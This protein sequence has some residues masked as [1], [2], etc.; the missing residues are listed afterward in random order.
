MEGAGVMAEGG[1]GARE[2]GG[3]RRFVE[4]T[5]LPVVW[6]GS[7]GREAVAGRQC[8]WTSGEWEAPRRC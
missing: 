2:T 4:C 7:S 3:V 5:Y 1:L 6:Q 8:V